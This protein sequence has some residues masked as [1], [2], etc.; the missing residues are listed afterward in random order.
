VKIAQA[1]ARALAL[2]AACAVEMIHAPLGTT[3]CRRW[4]TTRCGEAA[5]PRTSLRRR[6]R[7][8]AGDGL[9]T[10]AFGVSRVLAGL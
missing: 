9:L 4:T 3:T 10:E 6:A 2:P 5:R 7:D 1:T 8:P